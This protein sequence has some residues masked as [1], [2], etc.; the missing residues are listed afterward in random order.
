MTPRTAAAKLVIFPWLIITPE[1]NGRIITF[2]A[3]KLL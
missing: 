2:C 3:L 1:M